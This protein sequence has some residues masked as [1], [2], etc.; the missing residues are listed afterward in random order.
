MILQSC[1]R[2]GL[3]GIPERKEQPENFPGAALQ[4]SPPT[5]IDS[6]QVLFFRPR[7][8]SDTLVSREIIGKVGQGAMHDFTFNL[9]AGRYEIWVFGN[10]PSARVMAKAPYSSD[11]IWLD[12]NHGVQPGMICYG[13]T[14]LDA[15]ID[16]AKVLGLVL[17]SSAIQ[18]TVRN[19]PEGIKRITAQLLNTS[20]GL[21]LNSGYL[22]NDTEPPVTVSWEDVRA[23]S[24]YTQLI[25]CLPPA[26]SDENTI[27]KV[28]CYKS[29]GEIAYSGTSVPFQARPGYNWKLS[30]AFADTKSVVQG[31]QEHKLFFQWE[32]E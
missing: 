28:E 19:V 29:T 30:C 20:A 1:A 31:S 2:D 21:T 12:Y 4:L 18:L 27:V 22:T 14:L 7:G 26:G 10:V 23:D 16:T 15:G 6:A 13:R 5:D 24:T 25:Y 32:R 8:D 9:P 17:L 11:D 3:T